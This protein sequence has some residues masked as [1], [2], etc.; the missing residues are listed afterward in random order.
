MTKPR[1]MKEYWK[2]C[3]GGKDCGREVNK[4]KDEET[5]PEC[6]HRKCPSCEKIEPSPPLQDELNYQHQHVDDFH[7]ADFAH[8]PA[9]YDDCQQQYVFSFQGLAYADN[10]PPIQHKSNYHPVEHRRPKPSMRGWW[11]CCQCGD[12]VNP[13][14]NSWTCPVCYHEKCDSGCY[15]HQR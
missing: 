7:P 1:T 13:E 2:C 14:T 5:C 11:H 9:D 8:A 15:I 6:S 10:L 4:T 3:G 12:D